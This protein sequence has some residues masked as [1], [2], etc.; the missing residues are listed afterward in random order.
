[1]TPSPERQ[2]H[3]HDQVPSE[4]PEAAISNE[5]IP[6]QEN[7]IPITESPQLAAPETDA[8]SEAAADDAQATIIGETSPSI[9]PVVQSEPNAVSEAQIPPTEHS[10]FAEP[11]IA[12]PEVQVPPVDQLDAGPSI[13]LSTE[14]PQADASETPSLTAEEAPQV[15]SAPLTESPEEPAAL[16]EATPVPTPEY[17]RLDDQPAAD[18]QPAASLV[19]GETQHSDEIA[20]SSNSFESRSEADS[21]NIDETNPEQHSSSPTG[22]ASEEATG[23]PAAVD[24]DTPLENAPLEEIVSEIS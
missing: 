24:D 2:V 7:A 20:T 8:H 10:D 14:L 5:L 4:V 22:A 13:E 21:N 15:P 19:E 12:E 23:P 1:M 17:S 6:P 11:S 16:E 9:V 3:L 18:H